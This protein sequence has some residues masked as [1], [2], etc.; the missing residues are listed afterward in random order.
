MK[1]EDVPFEAHFL[2]GKKGR[3]FGLFFPAL[4]DTK[5]KLLCVPP[6]TEEANRCRVMIGMAARRLAVQGY[7]VLVLD[8]FGTGDSQGEFEQADWETWLEDIAI[9]MDWLADKPGRLF[10][11]GV[12]LGAIL[13]LQAVERSRQHVS[14]VIFW[15]PVISGKQ[16]FTQFLRLR[17]ANSKEQHGRQE[18]TEQLRQLLASGET[19][20]I[21]GYY[22]TSQLAA[23]LD[24]AL[25]PDGPLPEGLHVDWLERVQT[26]ETPV[27]MASQRWVSTWQEQGKSIAVHA[28][29]GPQFWQLHDRFLAPD[30]LEKTTQALQ[31]NV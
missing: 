24:A 28:F 27:S 3:L 29:T 23:A 21:G 4:G 15:Q 1:L 30:L 14:R 10:L 12:R 31:A 20:E 16:M 6:F 22:L 11:W 18:T 8:L 19:L 7:A 2:E 17:V 9:G 26:A 13:A 5:G 25:L